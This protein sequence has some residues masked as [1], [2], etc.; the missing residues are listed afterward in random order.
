[1]GI[2]LSVPRAAAA[3]CTDMGE[4][5][6]D[7]PSSSESSCYYTLKRERKDSRVQ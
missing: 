3:Q 1:M 2:G 7:Y 6:L 5:V 4:G